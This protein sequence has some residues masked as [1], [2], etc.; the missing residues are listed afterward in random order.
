MAAISATPP[1]PQ[2]SNGVTMLSLEVKTV[3]MYP[4]LF[5]SNFYVNPFEFV[6]MDISIIFVFFVFDKCENGT[7]MICVFLIVF[8]FPFLK[9]YL[10]FIRI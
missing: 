10:A 6:F 8:V 5:H 4:V 2:S 7:E 9:G 1:P 3:R